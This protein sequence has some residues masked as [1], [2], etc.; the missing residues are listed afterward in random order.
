MIL[1]IA[2]SLNQMPL[3]WLNKQYIGRKKP[4][5]TDRLYVIMV[6]VDFMKTNKIVFL[7]QIWIYFTK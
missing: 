3:H 2:I 5:N 6:R 4:I 1:P 7:M